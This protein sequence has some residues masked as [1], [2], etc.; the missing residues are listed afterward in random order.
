MQSLEK[1][2]TTPQI[3]HV[4]GFFGLGALLILLCEN[5]FLFLCISNHMGDL[6]SPSFVRMRNFV[7]FYFLQSIFPIYVAMS[8][9]QRRRDSRTPLQVGIQLLNWRVCQGYGVCVGGTQM[10]G[11]GRVVRPHFED[12]FSLIIIFERIACFFQFCLLSIFC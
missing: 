1:C 3:V 9:P 5:F 10:P 8:L 6:K 12:S 4:G 2:P 11:V 7:I